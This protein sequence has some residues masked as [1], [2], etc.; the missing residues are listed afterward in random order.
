MSCRWIVCLF[1]HFFPCLFILFFFCVR[2]ALVTDFTGPD[3]LFP[4]DSYVC[5]SATGAVK[6]KI[7]E[8]GIG[9]IPPLSI[10]TL[11]QRTVSRHMD[12]PALCVKRDGQVNCFPLHS[13]TCCLNLIKFSA[14]QWVKW[15][16]KQYLHDVQVCA[17]AF[18]RLGLERFH[19]VCILGFNSPEWFI[20]DLAAIHAG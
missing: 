9:S 11:L 8:R 16:Y 1:L 2:R 4:A 13:F 6:L 14:W 15:T 18:I 5:T 7:D 10:P 19:S 12:K 20:A 17:R 3:Q